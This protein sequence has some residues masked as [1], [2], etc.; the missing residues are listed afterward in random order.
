[1]DSFRLIDSKP[2]RALVEIVLHEGRNHIVRR[3]LAE[4]GHP[5]LQLV[6]TRIGPVGLGDLLPGKNRPL[7]RAELG[8]LMAQA[9]M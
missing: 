4:V 9:G 3:L 6:R 1:V 2:G 5:V 7:T 8:E